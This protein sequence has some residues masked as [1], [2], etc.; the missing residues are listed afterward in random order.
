MNA[1]CLNDLFS[2]LK[3]EPAK[4]YPRLVIQKAWMAD[5]MKADELLDRQL[6]PPVCRPVDDEN[7]IYLPT[8][9]GTIAL[10]NRKRYGAKNWEVNGY[11]RYLPYRNWLRASTG[12]DGS[13]GVLITNIYELR[14]IYLRSILRLKPAVEMEGD[15]VTCV[16]G[17]NGAV[18]EYR[19]ANGLTTLNFVDS[20]LVADII[21]A[22]DRRLN[23]YF[24]YDSIVALEG[25]ESA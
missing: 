20:N 2:R 17:F 14:S 21:D 19:V 13:Y 23:Q 3:L 11:I 22:G 6:T 16:T 9:R 5:N 15:V 1:Q 4:E 18:M 24:M 25:K 7:A 12:K 10:F 8:P